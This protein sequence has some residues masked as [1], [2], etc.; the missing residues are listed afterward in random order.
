MMIV[1]INSSWLED[2]KKKSKKLEALKDVIFSREDIPL[3]D[4]KCLVKYFFSQIT[5]LSIEYVENQIKWYKE[6]STEDLIFKVKILR[7]LDN[8]KRIFRKMDQKLKELPYKIQ[9]SLRRH[10]DQESLEEQK[11]AD[12][13]LV[14]NL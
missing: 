12:N 1:D 10:Q 9:G 2:L 4:R 11:Q 7:F 5:S 13:F 8:Q 14:N 6:M 3:A